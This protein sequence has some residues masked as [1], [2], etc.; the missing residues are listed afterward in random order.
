M[1]I[2]SND[3][4]EECDW[5]PGEDLTVKAFKEIVDKYQDEIGCDGKGFGGHT[6]KSSVEF[7]VKRK[8]GKD[9]SLKLVK[10]EPY[11]LIGCGCW[12][13]IYFYLEEEGEEY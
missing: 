8:D 3:S 10:T 2:M 4:S 5:E 9:Q 12:G 1:V 6:F 13:G 7:I 11:R